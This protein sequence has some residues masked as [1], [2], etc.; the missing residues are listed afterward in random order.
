MW[1]GLLHMEIIRERLSREHSLIFMT[2]PS[3]TYKVEIKMWRFN[4]SKEPKRFAR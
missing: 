2:V 3:V 1:L 4:R